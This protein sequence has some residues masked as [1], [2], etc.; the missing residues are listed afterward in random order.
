[1]IASRHGIP[2]LALVAGL[3]LIAVCGQFVGSLSPLSPFTV[4]IP[5]SP[6]RRLWFARDGV[7]YLCFEWRP[8][9]IF[10]VVGLVVFC[11]LFTSLGGKR[12]F[13]FVNVLDRFNMRFVR[14][15]NRSCLLDRGRAFRMVE[16]YWLDI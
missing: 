10:V 8:I 2:S 15:F 6:H 4:E 9:V 5:P 1:M 14:R 16:I 12:V 3:L 11:P 13:F 7:E